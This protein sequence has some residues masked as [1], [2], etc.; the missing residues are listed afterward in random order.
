MENTS[1]IIKPGGN[2]F[3]DFKE[4]WHFRDLM[5]FLTLR[6]IQIRYKQTLFGFLWFVLVPV[7]QMLVFGAIFGKIGKLSPAG[8]NPFAFYIVGLV[9]WQLFAN[10]MVTSTSSLVVNAGMLTKVYFPRII[11]P[12]SSSMSK[13]V[14]YLISLLV[15]FVILMGL[16]LYPQKWELVLLLPTIYLLIFVN[17]MGIGM[18][19]ASLNVK[20]RDISVVVP[21][22][23]QI[24]MFLS[25]I[26]PSSKI[27]ENL[28]ILYHLNP[29]AGLIELHRWCFLS[30]YTTEWQTIPWQGFLLGLPFTVVALSLGLWYFNRTEQVF[31]DIV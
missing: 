14:D 20:Y 10:C 5:Y 6:D 3:F 30:P 26:A 7:I 1:L 31:A 11:L 22:I 21:F 29:M 27:P 19:F 23:V 2:R 28:R 8:T 24:W 15:M 25:V 4:L 13:L 18:F 9:P 17:A 12:L 16:K